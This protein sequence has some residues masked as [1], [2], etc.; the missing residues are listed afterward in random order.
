MPRR[1]SGGRVRRRQP[2]R[3]SCSQRR[4]QLHQRR[5]DPQCRPRRLRPVV[6]PPRGLQKPAT[7]L[8]RLRL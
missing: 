5:C 2:S 7:T 1:T 6:R 8:Q 3:R 4:C